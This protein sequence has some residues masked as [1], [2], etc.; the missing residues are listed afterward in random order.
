MQA[1]HSCVKYQPT[2]QPINNLKEKEIKPGTSVSL[3]PPFCLWMQY[4]K[5]LQVPAN[6]TSLP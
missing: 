1:K 2:D 6:V 5:L 4:G 3:L